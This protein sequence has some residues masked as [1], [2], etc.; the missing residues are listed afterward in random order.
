[1]AKKEITITEQV[2]ELIFDIQ[3]K[4]YITGQTRESAD[5]NYEIASNMQIPDDNNALYQIRR[6]LSTAFSTLKSHI[7]EYLTEDTINSDN[8]IPEDID[9]NDALTIKLQMPANYNNASV[10]NISDSVHS[11]LVNS[12]L[13]AWF[14][15]TN[16]EESQSYSTMAAASLDN[17]LKSLCKRNRPERPIYK[18]DS[19]DDTSTMLS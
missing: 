13:A 18:E 9:D 15:I 8:L 2:K 6:T 14:L 16:K 12:A 19:E 7:S 4:A 1:M 5:S 17:I 10:D 3:N 11:Y